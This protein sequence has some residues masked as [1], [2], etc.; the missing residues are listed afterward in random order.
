MKQLKNGLT[1]FWCITGL[2]AV[3]I[4]L[5]AMFISDMPRW[6]IPAGLGYG[7]FALLNCLAINKD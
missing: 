3:I 1:A 6:E 4:A 7:L 2:T 5:F